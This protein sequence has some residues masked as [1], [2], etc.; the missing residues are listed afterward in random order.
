MSK[1]TILALIEDPGMFDTAVETAF[2]TA[3]DFDLH[4]DVLHI[5]SDLRH[6]SQ[7]SGVAGTLGNHCE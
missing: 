7:R 4:L 5:K 1:R 6:H 2:L 3:R